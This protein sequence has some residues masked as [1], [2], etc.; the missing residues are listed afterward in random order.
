MRPCTE[1]YHI[2]HISE[3]AELMLYLSRQTAGVEGNDIQPEITDVNV[4]LYR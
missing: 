3:H 4:L 1:I 2:D